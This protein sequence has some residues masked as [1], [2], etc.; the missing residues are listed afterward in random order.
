MVRQLLIMRHAKS[1]WDT[2]VPSDF[3]RP[4]ARR[5]L[6]DAPRMGSWLM[7]QKLVPDYVVSSPAERAKQTTLLV[8]K[9][10]EFRKRDIVWDHRIYGAGSED[11]LE[12]LSDAPKKSKLVMIVG[13]N[14]GL[15]F[16]VEYLAGRIER[17]E[18]PAGEGETM[19]VGLVRTA[20]I[21]HLKMPEDWGRFQ[22]GSATLVSIRNPR[23]LE[24]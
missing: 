5:G 14:P 11:L 8:C 13:H 17:P 23:D 1:A 19:D 7:E 9:A 18:V 22:M 20:T 10:L 24:S 21:V 16:L 3:D 6:R 2:D 15:E 4:L 12:V